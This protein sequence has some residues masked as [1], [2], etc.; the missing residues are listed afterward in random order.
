VLTARPLFQ[1]ALS[2]E[3]PTPSAL[4]AGIAESAFP[5]RIYAFEIPVKSADTEQ[6]ARE[7]EEPV[8]HLFCFPAFEILPELDF[9]TQLGRAPVPTEKLSSASQQAQ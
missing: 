9:L 3:L 5:R 6:I 7:R 8:Q 2:N 4:S 1:F